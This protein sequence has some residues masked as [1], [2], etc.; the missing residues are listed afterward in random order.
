ML[1]G[2]DGFQGAV[3]ALRFLAGLSRA[4]AADALGVSVHTLKHTMDAAKLA[5][6]V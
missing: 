2:M 3:M 5:A 4:D 6:I 1:K